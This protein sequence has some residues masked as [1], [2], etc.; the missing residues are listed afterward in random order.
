MVLD[1][2]AKPFIAKLGFR[3]LGMLAIADPS[4]THVVAI[5]KTGLVFDPE[6]GFFHKDWKEYDFIAMLEFR[7]L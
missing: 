2:P 5:D 7:P 1:F 4:L 6:N 3:Y